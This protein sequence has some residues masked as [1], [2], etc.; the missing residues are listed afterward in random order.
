MHTRSIFILAGFLAAMPAWAD[1]AYKWIDEDGI[2]HYSD[3]PVDGAQ[4]VDLSAYGQPTGAR[5]GPE[6]TADDE[7]DDDADD[8][9]P[10]QY[11]N[12][13]IAS[14]AAEETLWNIEGILNVSLALTPGLQRGHQI[15]VYF[16]GTPRIVTAQTFEIEE[17]WRGVHNIQAEVID[18]VGRL[19]IRSTP[20]RFYVQQNTVVR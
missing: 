16:D 6:D 1:D 19:M 2:V 20:N 18:S 13:A 17:V 9:R 4:T 15:R 5:M 12:L 11:E 10:F 8:N 7:Q 14:P 3:V